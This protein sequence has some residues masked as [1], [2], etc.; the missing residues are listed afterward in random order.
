MFHGKEPK[1][2]M[3]DFVDY[4]RDYHIKHID[5]SSFDAESTS[6]FKLDNRWSKPV[7]EGKVQHLIMITEKECTYYPLTEKVMV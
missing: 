2:S 6:S 4:E 1:N 3:I 5:C 7:P